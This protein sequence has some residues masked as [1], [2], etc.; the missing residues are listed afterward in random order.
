MLQI[1]TP[2]SL[3][4]SAPV[5]LRENIPH[6]TCGCTQGAGRQLGAEVAIKHDEKVQ[7]HVVRPVSSQPHEP[8]HN[9]S[10]SGAENCLITRIPQHRS[11]SALHPRHIAAADVQ[12]GPNVRKP[13]HQ[14]RCSFGNS[15]MHHAA[16]RRNSSRLRLFGLR[17]PQK[18]C[19]SWKSLHQIAALRLGDPDEDVQE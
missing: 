10:G 11:H 15:N 3:K 4:I 12:E 2:I 8:L 17:E 16:S 5:M 13:R 9:V 1:P 7:T 6:R 19:K 18:V 14:L